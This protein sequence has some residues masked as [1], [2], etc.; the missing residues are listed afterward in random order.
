M[1]SIAATRP[2][3]ALV[4][5]CLALT[6]ALGG[7]SY[8]AVNLPKNSIGTAHL[9]KGAVTGPKIKAQTLVARHF[10]QGQLPA[11]PQGAAGPAG[12]QGP[13]G[14]GGTAGPAGIARA[15]RTTRSSRL[16]DSV[17]NSTGA[18]ATATCPQG[19]KAIGGGV[20]SSW[21]HSTYGPV[22][23]V[24]MRL[25]RRLR[26]ERGH[27]DARGIPEQLHGHGE[28]GVRPRRLVGC[29]IPG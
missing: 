10:K 2:S 12:P 28:S 25:E 14:P 6:V 24:S 22:T 3:P 9:K 21:T 26:L 8:A 29:G 7:T 13:A 11:G 20:G 5:A 19:M 27:E 17:T 4:V 1:R 15:E 23:S 18:A 16:A